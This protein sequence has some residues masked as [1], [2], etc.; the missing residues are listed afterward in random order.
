VGAGNGPVQKVGGTDP[1]RNAL[2][3]LVVPLH[4]CGSKS[5]TCRF[6]KRFRDGQ[7]SLVSFLFA[8]L[9]WCPHAQP[10]VKV[11]ARVPRALCSRRHGLF[12]RTVR[13]CVMATAQ[14]K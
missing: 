4:F 7:Y 9:V 11:G 3:N 10:I 5:T 14:L 6:G 8:V 12:V 1:A 13:T 2:K